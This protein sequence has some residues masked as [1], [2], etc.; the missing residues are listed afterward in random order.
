MLKI[1]E[2][3]LIAKKLY[4]PKQTLFILKVSS[5]WFGMIME[6]LNITETENVHNTREEGTIKLKFSF[7]KNNPEVEL[8]IKISSEDKTD[9]DF[10]NAIYHHLKEIEKEKI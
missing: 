1:L 8:W 6:A 5:N 3:A 2:K 7:G 9:R 10:E 4:S